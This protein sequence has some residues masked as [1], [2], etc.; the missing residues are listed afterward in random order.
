MT[1][2]QR[3]FARRHLGIIVCDLAGWTKA[4]RRNDDLDLIE[5]LDAYYRLC[6]AELSAR[7]ARVIKFMGDSCMAIVE[8]DKLAPLVADLP[9][10]HQRI[11]ALGE[12]HR[13]PLRPGSNVHL[14]EVAAGEMG[15]A[16]HRRFDIIGSGVNHVFLMG[17]GPGIRISEPVY[18]QLPNQARGSWNKYRPPATYSFSESG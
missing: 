2:S 12:Q 3:R 15:P 5:F 16:G 13:M 1:E 7:G 18:R 6:H 10:L 8:P 17:G 14:A 11:E 4:S 9:A